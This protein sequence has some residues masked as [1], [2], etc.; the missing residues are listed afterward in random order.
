[1]SRSVGTREFNLQPDPR[2]L[3]MLGEINLPQ[4][5]CLAELIDN[6]IDGFLAARRADRDI[7]HAEVQVNLPTSDSPSAKVT[8]RDT[9]PGM[10]ADTLEKAVR[11][12]WTS[13]DAVNSLGMFGMGFNIA[14]ARLGILTKVWTTRENDTEWY[15]VEIDFERLVSQR[16]F[17]CPMLTRPKAEP[18]EHG[19]EVTVER[20]KPEQLQWLS[21]TSNQRRVAK[22]LQRTYSAM[23]RPDG[24][25]ISFKL[26]LNATVLRGRQHCVWGDAQ[27][28]ERSVQTRLGLVNA[29]QLIDNRLGPRPYCVRCWQW[30]TNDSPDCP[31]CDRRDAVIARERRVRGW[32]GIQRYLNTQEFGVD[33]IRHGRKIEISSKDLFV[34]TDDTGIE[35]E[36][37]IDD[38]RNRGRLVG[39]IHLDHC[40]V[41][42]MKDRFDRND[43]AWD[44]MVRIVRGEGPLRPDKARDL[45]FGENT[46]PLYRLYQAFRRSSPKPKVAGAYA[47][48]LVVLDNERAEEMAQHF[49]AGEADYQSD[50]RWH[51]L[52]AEADREL[53]APPAPPAP[54]GGED[55]PDIADF[56]PGPAAPPTRP[57]SAPPPLA[58]QRLPIP[59]LTQEYRD[60]LTDIRWNVSAYDVQ[61]ADTAL[62]APDAPWRLKALPAGGSEFM[63]RTGHEI[64]TSATLTP[65]DALLAELAYQ[66]LDRQRGNPNA[67]SFAR[68]FASLR[69]KYGARNKLDATSLAADAADALAAVARSLR[70]TISTE[71]SRALFDELTPTEQ[72]LVH[73]RMATRAVKQPQSVVD[74]GRFLEYAPRRTL[75]ALIER[76]PELF[77]DGKYWSE[78]YVSLDY[79]NSSITDEARRKTLEHFLGLL[80]DAIWLEELD[81]ADAPL[82][83]RER[84]LRA[85]LALDLLAKATDAGS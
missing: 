67:P 71:D 19:T 77:F 57:T 28:E 40:R 84:L 51:D 25:P 45:G 54:P 5:R 8:V 41:T 36:Y 32:I 75:L 29:F 39:E 24:I 61:A 49:Y 38:P 48:L 52:V 21:K 43:P 63:V 35:V 76:H 15:G 74:E 18:H 53:L 14:T 78:E 46:S 7:K 80:E 20:L 23:L 31:T 27:S 9:G 10:D 69:S 2:I 6:S 83:G 82:Y 65:I 26:G 30:L 17:M 56:A 44:E 50:Q 58:P 37:P 3:P 66:A 59:S 33:L 1:M 68:V 16:S 64:F 55:L 42:Y 4:W 34:W 22:E 79:N 72:G 13:N 60:D 12:G 85:A 62:D 47:K 81:P 70:G 11:A 73:H